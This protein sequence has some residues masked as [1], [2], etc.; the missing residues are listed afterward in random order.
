MIKRILAVGMV[1]LAVAMVVP[2]IGL[3]GV[4]VSGGVAQAQDQTDPATPDD[5]SGDDGGDAEDGPCGGEG[6]RASGEDCPPPAEQ[7]AQ[8]EQQEQPER[9]A[10]EQKPQE[11]PKKKH[12]VNGLG[13]ELATSTPSQTTTEVVQSA[14]PVAQGVD[15]GTIP[16]GGIQAGAGGTATDGSNADLVPGT[17]LMLVALAGGG[18]ALRRRHDLAS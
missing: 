14:T 4:F 9:S 6:A 18:F 13:D 12:N 2:A 5:D 15:T 7:P 16:T 1:S 11:Q 10:P 17:A 3:G 8:P